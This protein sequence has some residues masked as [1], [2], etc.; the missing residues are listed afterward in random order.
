M[1]SV[2]ESCGVLTILDHICSWYLFNMVTV[3]DKDLGD[4]VYVPKERY[5][6]SWPSTRNQVSPHLVP[7]S[8]LRSRFDTWSDLDII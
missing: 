7:E 1:N 4:S 8:A 6:T 5:G 3:D 2:L